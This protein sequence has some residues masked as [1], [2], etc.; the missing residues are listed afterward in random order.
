[1]I[2]HMSTSATDLDPVALV[3]DDAAATMSV[4]N[5]SVELRRCWHPIA[6]AAEVSELPRRFWQLDVALV[7]FRA[8]CEVVV[9]EDRCPHRRAPL[10]KGSVI[11]GTIQCAYHGWRFDASGSCVEIS[12]LGSGPLPRAAHA[13]TPRVLERGALASVALDD[14]IV[15]LSEFEQDDT[16]TQRVVDLEPFAGRYAAAMLIDNQLDLAHFA[17]V[18]RSTFG[19]DA[20]ARTPRY[21][22]E[23]DQ[24][25]FTVEVEVPI[26]AA[27]DREALDGRRSLAQ[28]RPMRYRYVAP[29]F[30][31]LTL[32]YPVMGG[33]TVVTFFAQP[34]QAAQARLYVSLAFSHPDGFS[35]DELAERVAFERRVVGEDLELQSSFDV[36]DLPLQRD[37]ECHVRADRAS[38]GF[39]RILTSRSAMAQIG[40]ADV[41]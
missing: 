8:N 11:D 16:A 10:S 17:F 3:G 24:W 30:V 41:N 28:H 1:M 33:S 12:S 2:A 31:E 37:A 29:F 22:I 4:R 9:L 21:E 18:H 14:P 23:R 27:N 15:D 7:A 20:A 5:G 6:R 26:T 13:T 35:E 32:I 38:L 39:R 40:G 25:G 19:S 34:L 36:L